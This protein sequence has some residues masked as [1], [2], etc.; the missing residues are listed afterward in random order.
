MRQLPDLRRENSSNHTVENETTH[1]M[2]KLLEQQESGIREEVNTK[3]VFEF[4]F[5][6]GQEDA[7]STRLSDHETFRDEDAYMLLTSDPEL[8]LP[9]WAG[10][11]EYAASD[12]QRLIS[13]NRAI[14]KG[15]YESPKYAL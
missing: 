1:K 9:F 2:S 10:S 8:I 5:S 4:L 6:L 15:L 13:S 14:L 7:N 11:S 3:G 12:L